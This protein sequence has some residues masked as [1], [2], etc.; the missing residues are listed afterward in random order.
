MKGCLL[1]Q[2]Y[3]LNIQHLKVMKRFLIAI[4]CLAVA[5][6]TM[7][8]PKAKPVSYVNA[9]ELT[10]I[11]KLCQTTNPYHRVEVANVDGISKGEARL[12]C[13]SS[14]LAIAF[15]TTSTA[16]YV[17]ATYGPSSRWNAH[18]PLASTTGF[19]LF[20]KDGKGEWI[21]AA[22]RAH[23]IIP[24]AENLESLSKP[25]KVISGMAPEEKECILY[26][27]LYSELTSLEIGVYQGAE[28]E[29]LPNPFR[30]NIAVFGSSFTHGSC[31][32]GAGLTWPAFLSRATGLHLCSFGMSGNSKLQ[33]YL[34]EVFGATKADALI[35]DAFSNPDIEQIRTRIRPF[36]EAVRK[37]NPNLPIIF[38]NTIYREHR[39]FQPKYDKREQA[40]IDFVEETLAQVVKEYKNIYFVNVPNQ[41]GTDH[42]TSADGTH[43]YSY[44]YH[45]WAQAIEK[46]IM[47]I[48]KKHKIK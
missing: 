14:G 25:L 13:M 38:L 19:N 4:L 21:W 32:S 34:G 37:G 42:I 12:L 11:G 10:M 24:T 6:S 1:G 41:T 2:P 22:S 23:K 8:A 28:I 29:A 18:A 40:R 7:A 16:I 48:L 46:P 36:I 17:K 44:G 20:I 35:C 27:P 26:L 9:T 31:A 15:K 45:R 33:P 30:H 43:P 5:T 3:F 47:K 39:N